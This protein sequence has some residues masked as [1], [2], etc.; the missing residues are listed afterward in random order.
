MTFP[1]QTLHPIENPLYIKILEMKTT[2]RNHIL[3]DYINPI[4]PVLSPKTSLR[5]REFLP[6]E[7]SASQ[8]Y[9]STAQK[10]NSIRVSIFSIEMP[11]ESYINS[12]KLA[13]Q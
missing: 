8:T 12:V 3:F 6:I 2:W 13:L 5:R 11:V 1:F 7:T 10:S 4:A 9:G